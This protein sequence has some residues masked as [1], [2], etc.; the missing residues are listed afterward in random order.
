MG[1]E[2]AIADWRDDRVDWSNADLVVIRSTWDYHRHPL[3]FLTWIE[4]TAARTRVCNG[5]DAVRWNHDKRYLLDL[6]RAGLPT[7][8]TAVLEPGVGPDAVGAAVASTATSPGGGVVV[9][10]TI[11][12]GSRDTARYGGSQVDRDRAVRHAGALLDAGRAV[13]VQ[14]FVDTVDSYGETAVV[15]F[16]GERSHA[17]RKGPMLRA[18]D[19]PD[20]DRTPSEELSPRVPT[21]AEIDVGDR[22]VGWLTDRFGSLLYTRVDLL[23]SPAGPVVLEVEV[24]EPALFCELAAG[25]LERFAEAIRSRVA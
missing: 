9:K 7:V 2:V 1:T 11:S 17:V 12:A 16:D 8:T 21:P 13:L 5:A 25:S 6:A 23:D 24:I 3:E 10:P 20:T 19:D 18:G 14:P 4:G 22:V 15:Y